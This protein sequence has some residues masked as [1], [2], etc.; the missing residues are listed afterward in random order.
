LATVIAYTANPSYGSA[1]SEDSRM[2]AI[3]RLRAMKPSTFVPGSTVA[4]DS[5]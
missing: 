4:V 2:A 5:F 1:R 3:A